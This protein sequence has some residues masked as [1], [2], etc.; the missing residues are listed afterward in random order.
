MRCAA[1]P[2]TYTC[3]ALMYAAPPPRAPGNGLPAASTCGTGP[4]RP[5]GTGLRAAGEGELEYGIWRA[6]WLAHIVCY[7]AGH[8]HSTTNTPGPCRITIIAVL[9]FTGETVPCCTASR[10]AP[11]VATH[12]CCR[13]RS[14]RTRDAM[15]A[16]SRM[17]K[18][19]KET[20]EQNRARHRHAVVCRG[21]CMRLPHACARACAR[22]AHTCGRGTRV[23]KRHC[24]PH[25]APRACVYCALSFR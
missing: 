6:A 10:D 2:H 18:K 20:P 4:V 13:C 25:A 24:W 14:A 1:V 21:L 7:N 16:L 19:A 9:L 3:A 22:V 17:G 15:Y 11:F 23:Q 12:R 8:G 5:V